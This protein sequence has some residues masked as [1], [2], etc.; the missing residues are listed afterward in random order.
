MSKTHYK[1]VNEIT[2]AAPLNYQICNGVSGSDEM[3][4]EASLK[5]K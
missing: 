4:D 3:G 2:I 5:E 1:N